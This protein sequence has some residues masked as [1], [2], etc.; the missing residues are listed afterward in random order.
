MSGCCEDVEQRSV[1]TNSGQFLEEMNC[2]LV[3]EVW[4]P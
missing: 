3:E 2:Q 1:S 4:A